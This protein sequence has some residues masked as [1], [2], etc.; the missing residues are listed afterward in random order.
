MP[1]SEGGILS[2]EG[3]LMTAGRLDDCRGRYGI[4]GE[5]EIL[6]SESEITPFVEYIMCRMGFFGSTF[7]VLRGASE[8]DG[9]EGHVSSVFPSPKVCSPASGCAL[10][11]HGYGNEASVK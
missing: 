5:G 1:P 9:E 4:F 6:S 11:V 3:G 10:S 2:S 8:A 7:G